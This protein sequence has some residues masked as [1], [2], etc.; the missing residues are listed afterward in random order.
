MKNK[1]CQLF[2]S[3]TWH[4]GKDK[5]KIFFFTCSWRCSNTIQSSLG[6]SAEREGNIYFISSQN[7]YWDWELLFSFQISEFLKELKNAVLLSQEIILL[8]TT[9]SAAFKLYPSLLNRKNH[10]LKWV[11]VSASYSVSHK[12]SPCFCCHSFV[13]AKWCD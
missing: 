8:N 13:L 3:H 4:R 2:L 9:T 6:A 10:R 1:F 7:M 5:W 12:I 11:Y